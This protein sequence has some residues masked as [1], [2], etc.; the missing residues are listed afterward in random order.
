MFREILF[1]VYDIILFIM[2]I[3]VGDKYMLLTWD[4]I[5]PTTG[6]Q[7]TAVRSINLKTAMLLNLYIHAI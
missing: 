3:I 2:S 1:M 5:H 6:F 4:N 7:V